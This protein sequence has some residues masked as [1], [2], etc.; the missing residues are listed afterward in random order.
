MTDHA[1]IPYPTPEAGPVA[2]AAADTLAAYVADGVLDQRLDGLLIA[3]VTS[4]ASRLDNPRAA[5]Y[6]LAQVSEQLRK[7]YED[8]ERRRAAKSKGNP[9][10]GLMDED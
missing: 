5:A 4:L 2:R 7:V 9:L 10:A 8:L 1:L 3:H 6:G